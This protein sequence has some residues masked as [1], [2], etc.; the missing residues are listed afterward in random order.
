M[1][2]VINTKLF[3]IFQNMTIAH[4]FN[5]LLYS[6]TKTYQ[7]TYIANHLGITRMTVARALKWLKEEG[8]ITYKRDKYKEAITTKFLLTHKALQLKKEI[9]KEENEQTEQQQEKKENRQTTQKQ[10]QEKKEEKK[11][12]TQIKREQGDAPKATPNCSNAKPKQNT[13]RTRFDDIVAARREYE[14]KLKEKFFTQNGKL[15]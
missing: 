8:Y 5:M 9:E 10:Q 14:D 6:Q 3:E 2:I 15:S 13:E 1:N 12:T 4:I 11:E 7:Q